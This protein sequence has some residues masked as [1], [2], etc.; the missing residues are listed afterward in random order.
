MVLRTYVMAETKKGV[1]PNQL[2]RM[3]GIS[4]KT[5]WYLCHRI[6]KAMTEVNPTKLSGVVEID[7]TYTGGKK[8]YVGRGSLEGK[9]MVLGAI[10]R[11]GEIRL[12]VD[13]RKKAS[14]KGSPSFRA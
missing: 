7:E 9:T 5:A 1:S 14:E 2:K 3:L 12:R 13:K 4:Y 8:C 6:R 10:Q 11:G